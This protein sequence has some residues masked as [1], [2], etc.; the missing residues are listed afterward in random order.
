MT[1]ELSFQYSASSVRTTTQ[2]DL[3]SFQTDALVV[4]LSEG[5]VGR[6]KAAEIN[7]AT[8][9]LL[10]KLIEQGELSGERYQCT[11][12]FEPAGLAT[13]HL[14]IVGLGK[15]EDVDS[16]I[17]FR[18]AAAASRQLAA[19]PRAKVAFVADDYWTDKHVEQAVAGAMSG[20][21]GQDIYRSKKKRTPFKNTIWINTK[22]DTVQNGGLLGDG[23]NLARHLVNLSPDDLYPESFAD[24]ACA[25]AGKTGMKIEI[26]DEEKLTQ[27]GCRG[28]LA[29]GRGGHRRPRL[30][31]MHYNGR[32]DSSQPDVSLVGKGVT[33]DSGG[34]SLKSPDGMLHMKCDMA[35]GATMLAAA[36]T[37]AAMKLPIN[38]VAAIGLVENMTGSAAYKVGDVITARSG[39]TVEI[40]NTDAEGRVVLA[41]VLDV[42]RGLGTKR[43]IDAATL[44]GACV[45]ALGLDV[46]GLFSNNQPLCD[47]VIQS[48]HDMGEPVWQ[49]PMFAEYDSQIKSEVA[50]IKNVG[51]G[52]WGGA[53]TAAKFLEQFV[54]DTPWTHIDI[55]GPAFAEKPR[56]WIDGGGTGALVRTLISLARSL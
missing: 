17:L 28:I 8:D 40:H 39:T 27:E 25:A 19:S 6:G 16:G 43:I 50:D 2:Y 46:A 53:I 38:I 10:S 24:H 41:D 21:I 29:V 49:L 7:K 52:R 35:G 30:V 15:R 37:I 47:H 4:F 5:D 51:N 20:M 12:L 54:G 13:P 18:A 34:L 42:V 56:P 26:W 14:L 55:A 45:V 3:G 31:L 23:V 33:F 11:S 44:T 9:G 36:S 32:N 48:A 22:N 1:K